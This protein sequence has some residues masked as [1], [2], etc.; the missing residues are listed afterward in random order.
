L[1]IRDRLSQ[2]VLIGVALLMGFLLGLA[3]WNNSF[4]HIL[5]ILTWGDIVVLDSFIVAP[6]MVYAILLQRYS[7]ME[8]RELVSNPLRVAGWLSAVGM[9]CVDGYAFLQRLIAFFGVEIMETEYGQGFVL[10]IVAGFVLI[11]IVMA[12]IVSTVSIEK[13]SR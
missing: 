4:G 10:M 6:V 9:L 7:R 5:S 8:E 13:E 12:S 1:I 3:Q 11:C 2:I